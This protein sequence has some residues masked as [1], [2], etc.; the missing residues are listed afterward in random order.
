MVTAGF[1]CAPEIG[2][3][4]RMIAMSAPPVA[5]VFASRAMA[6]LPPANR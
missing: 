2:P 1:K 5:I 3:N 6:T 4:A